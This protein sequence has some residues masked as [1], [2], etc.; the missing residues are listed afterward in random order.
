M[1]T[2]PTLLEI[3]RNKATAATEEMGITLQ[4]AG[5][6]L[7]VKETADY[8]TALATP[9][10]KFFAFPVGV[11]VAGFVDLDCGPTIGAMPDLELGDV[12]ITNHPYASGGLATHTPD[13]QLLRPYFD[14]GEI[15]AFGWSFIHSAD[16]GGK[17]P[18]SVSP[19]NTEI[20]QEGLLIPPTKLVKRGEL[21]TEFLAIYRANCR[22]PDLNVGDLRAMLAALEVGARRVEETIARY[23]RETFLVAQEDLMAYAEAKAREAFRHLPDGT[24]DFWDYLDD[25]VFSPV[26]VRLRV[27]MAV[28]DG[29]IHLDFAGTDPQTRAPFNLATG[30]RSHPWITLRLLAYAVTRV[31]DCPVNSGVFRNVSVEVRHGTVLDPEFPAPTGIRAASGVRCYDVLNGALA[32]ADPAFMPGTPGGN[33]VPLVLV[34]PADATSKEK[35]TVVQFMVGATGG[36]PGADGVDGRDPSFTNMANNPIETIESETSA[37]VHRYGIATDSGGPGEWRGGCGQTVTFEVT[38]DGC[39]LLARGLERLHFS[40]W[41]AC[42]GRP[43]T[44]ARVVLN[45]GTAQERNLGKLDVVDLERGD[46][47]T[48]VMAGAG[49]W[50]DPLHRPAAAVARDV[51]RGFVSRQA[52]ERDYAVLLQEDGTPDEVA[53]RHLRGARPAAPRAGFD[54]G[55]ERDAWERVFDDARMNRMVDKLLSMPREQRLRAR[56]KLFAELDERLAARGSNTCPPFA[57]VLENAERLGQR[58]DRLIDGLDEARGADPARA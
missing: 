10:G 25:D 14:G 54:F 26:P 2:D 50:G 42:G 3:L 13:I 28:A 43:A 35:V 7:Y 55:P 52:A 33:I 51:A 12:V 19:T 22:T 39:R 17:V 21:N 31:P 47:V 18:S 37:I 57:R 20:F 29:R 56:A 49:G 58:L 24:Y 40:P 4:R 15:V 38:K 44:P 1:R 23:G 48:A 36:R 27:R 9:A 45:S 16:I 5:R 34:E 8:G 46:S 32:S 11:G 53:T 41:G 6:T 30:G